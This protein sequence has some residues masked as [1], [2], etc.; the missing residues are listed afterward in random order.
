MET[1]LKMEFAS[2]E[3]MDRLWE[4][5]GFSSFKIPESDK[6]EDYETIYLDT[7]DLLLRKYGASLRVRSVNGDTYIHTI[8]RKIDEKDGLHQRY[9]WNCES[10]EDVF[11]VEDF[12]EHAISNGDPD[13]IL[14][15]ILH[16]LSGQDLR[17]LFR[18]VFVRKSFLA[19]FGDSLIEVALDFGSLRVDDREAPICE[20]ELE[21][22]EGDVRDVIDF[23]EEIL[24]HTE[25]K[26]DPR[27]KYSKGISL[28]SQV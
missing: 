17:E 7:E 8:K 22:K 13:S 6:E 25:A 20:M 3:D 12:A 15:E 10:S 24:S 14:E 23:G 4:D 21:L 27:S 16:L 28:L 1:E 9:E 26:L 5:P 19:G 11:S 2:A 18:T